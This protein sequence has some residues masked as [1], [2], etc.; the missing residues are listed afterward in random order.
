[1]NP[2]PST[3]NP[4]PS[5]LTPQPSTLNPQPST[6]HP[7]PSTLHQVLENAEAYKARLEV[8]SKEELASRTQLATYGD[9]F[10]DFQE[11][12]TKSND[13]FASFKKESDKMQ[14]RLKVLEKER[15]DAVVR[16][17]KFEKLCI[18]STE[19]LEVMHLEDSQN[20]TC[21]ISYILRP[22][23]YTLGSKFAGK[24]LCSSSNKSTHDVPPLP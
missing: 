20:I 8:V 12:L 3:L 9:K 7:P 10:K 15:K 16:G 22:T 6:L 19:S 17:D 4:H 1:L 14:K 21:P 11:T 23:L 24:M 5:P 2:Q 13:M 18:D